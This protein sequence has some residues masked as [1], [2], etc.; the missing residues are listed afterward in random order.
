MADVLEND[1][2]L[3]S[4]AINENRH[5]DHTSGERLLRFKNREYPRINIPNT[6]IRKAGQQYQM[7]DNPYEWVINGS[8][9]AKKAVDED[10]TEYPTLDIRLD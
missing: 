10:I 4:Y 9:L 2:P 8:T 6:H 5:D 3:T 1:R 7:A